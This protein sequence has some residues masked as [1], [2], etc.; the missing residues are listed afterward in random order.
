MPNMFSACCT[1]AFN[2]G[3]H[4]CMYTQCFRLFS[5]AVCGLHY[6]SSQICILTCYFQIC[7]SFSFFGMILAYSFNFSSPKSFNILGQ[8]V[9]GWVHACDLS[10][11]LP[12]HHSA[13]SLHHHDASFCAPCIYYNLLF[14]PTCFL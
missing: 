10:V 4:P 1:C 2:G 5:L 11:D 12:N 9:A 14:S 7:M 8:S 3:L 13:S 6:I